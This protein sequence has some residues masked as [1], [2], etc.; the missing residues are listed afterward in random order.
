MRFNALSGAATIGTGVTAA[1][2][3][4]ATLELAGTVSALGNGS[5]RVNITNNSSAAAGILVSGTHQIV[6]NI[7]GS[8][9]TQVNAGSDLMANHIVQSALVIGGAV[10]SPAVVTI[11]AS[12]ASGNPLVG[13]ALPTPPD[14]NA[15]LAL[16]AELGDSLNVGLVAGNL[17]SLAASDSAAVPEPSS[18]FLLAVGGLAPGAPSVRK[19][20]RRRADWFQSCEL[21]E[22]SPAASL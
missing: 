10:G 21:Q 19:R 9:T 11:D 5:G 18:L 8:G 15:P 7:D 12:D 22:S 14:A 1:V 17:P 13:P 16:G 4:S 3:N 20:L 2:N 6:G